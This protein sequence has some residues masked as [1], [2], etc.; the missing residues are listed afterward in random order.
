M[1]HVLHVL[2]VA[3]VCGAVVCDGWCVHVCGAVEC[4]THTNLISFVLFYGM[5]CRGVTC[6]TGLIALQILCGE[7]MRGV[8]GLLL[9]PDGGRFVD[10]LSPRDKVRI[11][12]EPFHTRASPISLPLPNSTS[13]ALR[14]LPPILHTPPQRW[15][16]RRQL[17]DELT[18]CCS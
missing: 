18:L 9:T 4:G 5:S 6:V 12:F 14:F 8:G 10:E 1:L 15:S 2:C 7:L 13:L 17:L 3:R 16:R 11:P